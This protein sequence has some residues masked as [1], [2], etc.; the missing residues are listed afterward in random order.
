MSGNPREERFSGTR[1]QHQGQV[2]LSKHTEQ[3]EVLG[4]STCPPYPFW[5]I[6]IFT[7]FWKYEFLKCWKQLYIGG[8]D[9]K[10]YLIRKKSWQGLDTL[11]SWINLRNGKA[12]ERCQRW[13]P[14]TQSI[15]KCGAREVWVFRNSE[16]L[17]KSI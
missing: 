10:W 14:W 15:P 11:F 3:R 13:A 12:M 4:L 8:E 9:L 1:E 7:D 5:A 2:L 16:L 6:R 17:Y